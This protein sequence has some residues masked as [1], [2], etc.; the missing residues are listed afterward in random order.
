MPLTN[1]TTS[2]D[3]DYWVNDGKEYT[4]NPAKEVVAETVEEA[5]TVEDYRRNGYYRRNH[6]MV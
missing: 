6:P 3:G 5:D 4:W 2:L 1:P